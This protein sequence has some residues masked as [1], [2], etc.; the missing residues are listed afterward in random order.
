MVDNKANNPF[1]ES[2]N[3]NPYQWAGEVGVEGVRKGKIVIPRMKVQD[4]EG[5]GSDNYVK[6][7]NETMRPYM[8]GGKK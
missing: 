3:G 7:S 5:S 2:F 4:H 1:K 8:K 6:E